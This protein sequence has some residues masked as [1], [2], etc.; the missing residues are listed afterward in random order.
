MFG[1]TTLSLGPRRHHCRRCGFIFCNAHSSRRLPLNVVNSKGALAVESVRVCDGCYSEDD[2]ERRISDATTPSLTSSVTSAPDAELV[3]PRPS[4]NRSQSQ[5]TIS[6]LQTPLAPIEDWMDRSGILSLYPLATQASHS[7]RS[8]TTARAAAP[9]FAPSL[10]ERRYVQEKELERLFLRQKRNARPFWQHSTPASDAE[11]DA[12]GEGS[13]S[14][15]WSKAERRS[16][17][18]RTPIHERALDWSTF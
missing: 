14:H 5:P 10:K 15:S 18:T 17:G 16:T 11:S 1:S 9:L 2:T 8:P 12:E 4:F 3:T 7:R 6:E 13:V